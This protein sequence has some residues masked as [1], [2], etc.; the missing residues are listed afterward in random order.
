MN[1]NRIIALALALALVGGAA[2]VTAYAVSSGEAQQA[3]AAEDEAASASVRDLE[4]GPATKD[5]TVYVIANADGSVEK[6]IVSDWLKNTLGQ[7]TLNDRSELTG[8]ENVKGDETYSDGADG[9]KVWNAQGNDIYYQGTIEKALPVEM[10]ITYLLDGK[11]I[12]PAELAGKS[13]RVT[14]RFDYK[15]RQYE[16]VTID[17]KEEKIYVPFAMLTGVLLDSERFSNVAVTNGKL[18]N[19]GDHT[20]VVGLAFPGL[21]EDLGL[22]ADK[23]DIPDYV[24]ITADVT[25]FELTTAVTVATNS[26]F[27]DLDEDAADGFDLDELNESLDKLTDAMDQLIDGSSELYD[28]LCTLLEKSGDLSDGVDQIANGLNR[29][30]ANNDSLNGGAKQV[31]DTLLAEA[32]TQIAASGLELPALTVSNYS[33]VLTAVLAQLDEPGTYAEAQARKQVEAAVRAQEDTIR[34]AVAQAVE[35]VV[36]E[37]VTAAV[38]ANVWQQV[39]AAADLTP[40]TYDAGVAA[41]A[42][43]AQQQAM[44]KAAL[45]QQMA[46]Q[47]AQTA[48]AQNL[49]AQMASDKVKATVDAKVEE[50]I[51]SIVAQKMTDPEIQAKITEATAQASEGAASLRALKQ[52]LDSYNTFYTGLASYTAGVAAVRDGA[53]KLQS[54]MPALIKGITQLRDGAMQLSDGLKEFNEEGVQ[55]LVDAVDGDLGGLGDRLQAVIDVSRNYKTFSGISD[56]M[57]GSVKFVYRTEAITAPETEEQ[58]G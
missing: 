26:V 14:I 41:G 1:K 30:V 36:K 57:E 2:G 23:L 53:V 11:E 48:I 27:N 38:Q 47:A 49:E 58:A 7:A 43:S 20:A 32:N 56:D 52:Q 3:A 37:Q 18:I 33:E 55:K 24:E 28:G 31:F 50:Q 8:V 17:G 13:G 15:N 5:E 10:S 12:A 4:A 44:L 40:E 29:L 46:G 35:P 42:I 6:V 25:G 16:M 21:Q 54:N 9:A 34:T 39:L 19:D 22:D 51:Q 45:E